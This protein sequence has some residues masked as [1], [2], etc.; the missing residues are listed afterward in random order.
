MADPR[1]KSPPH[2]LNHWIL[3]SSML[4]AVFLSTLSSFMS[5]KINLKALKEEVP[6]T[7]V[8]TVTN[9]NQMPNGDTL[10]TADAAS[11]TAQQGPKD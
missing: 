5:L 3:A 1:P 8:M 2:A 9:Q 10:T 4:G 7:T 6:L 11:N